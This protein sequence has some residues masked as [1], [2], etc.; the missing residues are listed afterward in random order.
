MMNLEIKAII[1][2]I[3]LG[4][5]RNRTLASQS[6]VQHAASRSIWT[7]YGQHTL[8]HSVKCLTPTPTSCIREPRTIHTLVTYLSAHKQYAWPVRYPSLDAFRVLNINF[9]TFLWCLNYM[10]TFISVFYLPYSLNG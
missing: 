10:N 8:G 7:N 5:M 9:Q 1:L 4:S 6:Q 3:L 2:K